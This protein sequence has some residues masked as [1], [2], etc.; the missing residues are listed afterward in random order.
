MNYR[1]LGRSGIQVSPLCLGTMMFGDRTDEAEAGRIVD[2][3]RAGGTNFIDTADA[4]AKGESERIVGRL[5]ARD[6]TRWILA[7]KAANPMSDDPNDRGLSRRWLEAACNAS[8]KRLG[9]DYIDVYYLHR[10]DEETPLEETAATVG[11]LIRAGKIR[12]VGISNFR[13]WRMAT[14]IE[15]CKQMGVPQPVCCQ[16]YYNAFN[17]M[18]EVEVLPACAHHGLGVVPYSP[19]ARG[20]LTGKYDPKAAPA[21]DS[22]AGRKDARMLQTEFRRES[23][24]MAQTVKAHAEKRGMTAGQ[25]AVNWVLANPI[26][27][28]VLA[29]PRT[30]AQWEEYAGSLK[31]A[32]SA[33]D[34]TLIDGMVPIGHPSTPGYS[35]P[36]YPIRGR[37]PI[38]G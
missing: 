19:L 29:G 34:E 7:T 12:Y 20:V 27:T 10:E 35:D 13:A 3:A 4:Y 22:R 2:S 24:E 26:V 11:D 16:P 21:A 17:R 31:H 37:P 32:W 30:L 6:R 23:L 18:P 9:T 33:A 28:S 15:I 1:R 14:F 25:F 38:K 5:I 8:L 36:Q